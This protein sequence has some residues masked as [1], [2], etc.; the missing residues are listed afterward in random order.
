MERWNTIQVEIIGRFI[1]PLVDGAR[2]PAIVLAV[3]KVAHLV[4]IP[5]QYV[6]RRIVVEEAQHDIVGVG[7]LDLVRMTSNLSEKLGGRL[8]DRE[9]VSRV[10]RDSCQIVPSCL[11]SK[12]FNM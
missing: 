7:F 11:A 10:F 2:F 3:D 4:S 12:V 1:L 5:V 8:R 6:K 9:H